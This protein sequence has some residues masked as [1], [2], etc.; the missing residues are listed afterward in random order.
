[1]SEL[2][3]FGG[4]LVEG[5]E[6]LSVTAPHARKRKAVNPPHPPHTSTA[7]PEPWL[8]DALDRTARQERQRALRE[9]LRLCREAGKRIRHA[10]RLA[11]LNR[12]EGS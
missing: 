4:G 3:R 6:G 5:V 2:I 10:R 11:Q 9:E 1:M 8:Q 7:V 12:K